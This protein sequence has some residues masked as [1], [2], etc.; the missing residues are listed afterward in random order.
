MT[1]IN[2]VILDDK[3]VLISQI[4]DSEKN[5]KYPFL[6]GETLI[7]KEGDYYIVCDNKTG[8]AFV[9]SFS[10]EN[11]AYDWLQ[12][13]TYDCGNCNIELAIEDVKFCVNIHYKSEDVESTSLTNLEE[14]QYLLGHYKETLKNCT[15]EIEISMAYCPHCASLV[16]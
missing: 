7:K 15:K 6:H 13:M 9:Q 1:K 5:G 8:N 14:A 16:E 4:I 3:N 2:G 10:D 12:D 11:L